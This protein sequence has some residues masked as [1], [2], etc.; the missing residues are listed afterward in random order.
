MLLRSAFF[1]GIHSKKRQQ[2][3]TQ[4]SPDKERAGVAIAAQ[5][6]ISIRYAGTQLN[7]Y[8]ADVF[9]EA[10]HQARRDPLDTECVFTGYSLLTAIGRNLS[11]SSYEDLTESLKRLRNGSVEIE[12]TSKGRQYEFNGSLI[13]SYVREKES[14]MYKVTFAKEIRTL[15]APA[16]WTQIEWDERKSL[17]GKPLAQWLHSYFSTHAAPYPVSTAFLHEKTGSPTKELKH[18]KTELMNAFKAMNEILGWVSTWNE[19][20]VT[21]VRTPSASQVRHISRKAASKKAQKA[22]VARSTPSPRNRSSANTE[23]ASIKDILGSLKQAGE[24]RF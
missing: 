4:S 3:G 15:F 20:K 23:F 7:Q 11:K 14:K 9:F 17:K 5:D 22:L 10:L 18:F 8:D 21:L 13:A 2:L 1:A 19:D 16:S 12:W 24:R 6:G